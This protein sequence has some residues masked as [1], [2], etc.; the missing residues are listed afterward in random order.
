MLTRGIIDDGRA[1]SIS[2]STVK[3]LKCT[4]NYQWASRGDNNEAIYCQQLKFS[5]TNET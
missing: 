4:Q 3:K 1:Y 5:L 2:Y